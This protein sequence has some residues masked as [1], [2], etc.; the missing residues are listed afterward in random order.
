[1]NEDRSPPEPAPTPWE[2]GAVH[3]RPDLTMLVFGGGEVLEVQ[4][5]DKQA[6]G[7]SSALAMAVADHIP[8]RVAAA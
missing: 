8:Q 2:R 6:L 1:M 3:V 7:L 4:L 5:D